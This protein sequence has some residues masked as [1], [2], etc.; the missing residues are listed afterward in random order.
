MV[1]I[2]TEDPGV[3]IG[4][5][6]QDRRRAKPAS[7]VGDLRAALQFFFHAVECGNPTAGQVRNVVRTEKS[8]RTVIQVMVM[9]VP[10]NAFSRTKRILDLRSIVET[11]RDDLKRAGKIRRA[12]LDGQRKGLLRRKR[13]GAG[14]SIVG[15]VAARRVGIEPFAY[16]SFVSARAAGQFRGR[17]RPRIRHRL[18]KSEPGANKKQYGMHGGAHVRHS[19]AHERV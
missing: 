5:R 18:V 19:L 16:V 7:D 4:L 9:L 13:E 12:V 1:V 3:W 14:R 8:L 2:K 10:A 11:R 6:H 17:D 15:N